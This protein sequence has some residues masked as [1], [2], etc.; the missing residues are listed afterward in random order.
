[1]WLKELLGEVSVSNFYVLE[2]NCILRSSLRLLHLSFPRR[3]KDEATSEDANIIHRASLQLNKI[4]FTSTHPWS[5]YD[6]LSYDATWALNFTA[7]LHLTDFIT[8][9]RIFSFVSG[10]PG[11]STLWRNLA[12]L[13]RR[14][15]WHLLTLSFSLRSKASFWIPLISS[16]AAD[17]SINHTSINE[18]ESE[19][20]TQQ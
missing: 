14:W 17:L 19:K 1:M 2:R 3:L 10:I 12:D 13:L 20:T 4:S 9:A 8:F 16:T 15:H 7:S 5:F 11:I 6:F 18:P